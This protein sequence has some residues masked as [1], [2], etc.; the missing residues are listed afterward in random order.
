MLDRGEAPGPADVAA[1]GTETEVAE[2]LA[3]YADAGTT[4]L[5]AVVYPVGPDPERSVARTM[6]LLAGLTGTV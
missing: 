1:V 4:E 3:A 6:D 5:I 2:Q